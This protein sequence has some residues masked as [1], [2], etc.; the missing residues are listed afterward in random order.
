MFFALEVILNEMSSDAMGA[1][2]LASF[3]SAILTQAV[4]GPAP[5]FRV[6]AY[7]MRSAWELPLYVGLGL[8]AG[9][10][11][12][13]YIRLIYFMQD[14]FRRTRLP[15][16]TTPTLAG[17]ALGLIGLVL[18][19]VLGVGYSSIEAVLSGPAQPVMLLLVLVVAKL[20]LTPWS[21]GAGFVGGVFA[22]GL[23]I[24][25][26]LGAAYGL[27]AS[28]LF[29]SLGLS[30]SAFA[31]VGM[32]AVLSATIRAPLT[33]ILLLFEMTND[34]R[35]V[36]PLMLAVGAG[37]YLSERLQ[38][39]SVYILGLARKGIR[40]QRGR[41]VEVLDGLAVREVMQAALMTLHETDRLSA[42]GDVLVSS[43]HHG[44]PVVNAEGHLVGMFTVKDLDE[45]LMPGLAPEITIGKVLSQD[46]VTT[47]PDET[48]GAAL[49]RMS[50]ADIGRL[51][52]V[53]REDPRHLLGMLHRADMIRAYDL[54]LARRA[55][56]RHTGHQVRLGA[57]TG[58]A[59]E[60]IVVQAGSGCDGKMLGQVA[61][62]K[63][64][65]IASI[66]RG[67]QVIV[68]HG[69]TMLLAGDVLAVVEQGR[70]TEQVK[71]M[72]RSPE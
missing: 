41:D 38:R 6:P 29:P 45:A 46:L 1:I 5:A 59:V 60:E 11:A 9:P 67:G 44:L 68:P 39:D 40:L 32:A 2:L 14:F 50:Q 13:I 64:S 12:A 63:G 70:V 16:W 36:L 23:F 65:M 4:S 42:A 25:A 61:W 49:Q 27:M 33:G 66:R 43:R 69:G 28:S 52:V 47:F 72:C 22:P 3:S 56:E 15:R 54:A 55:A 48:V 62:P 35:I 18:P 8:L 51:P 57:F 20:V 10:I 71:R 58:V 21:L 19:Q 30:S 37:M 26:M 7:S 24:G 53:S 34:Y 17:V 31:M